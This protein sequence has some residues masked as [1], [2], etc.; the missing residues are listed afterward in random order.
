MCNMI[1][2]DDDKSREAALDALNSVIRGNKFTGRKML[3]EV[4][5]SDFCGLLC[6]PSAYTRSYAGRWYVQRTAWTSL[7]ASG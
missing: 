7:S 1:A 5:L 3:E 2:M 6:F 4:D